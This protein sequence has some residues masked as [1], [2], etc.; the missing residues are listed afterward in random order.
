MKRL[1]V[2]GTNWLG[3][4]V[5]TTPAL[6]RLREKFPDAHIALLTPEKLEQ[7]WLHHPAVD[8]FI[9]FSAGQ[10]VFGVA[11]K[12]RGGKFDAALVLPNSPRS[13]LEVFLAR[14][15]ARI[16]YARPWRNVFLTQTVVPRADAVKM[17][18]RTVQEIKGL[19][20][21]NPKCGI[22][23]PP[24]SQSAHQAHEYLHL[25]AAL[26]ANEEP[27]QSMLAVT[28][29]EVDAARQKFGLASVSSPI[30]GLNPGAEYGPAKRW[31]IER[32]ITAAKEIQ[33]RNN[34]AWILFGGNNDKDLTNQIQSALGGE[35]SVFNVAGKT[36]LRE[37]MS[38]MK[39]CRLFLTNDT[40]PMHVAAALGVPVVAIFGSTSPELTAPLMAN[41]SS[42][43][44]LAS[45][46]PCSPCF[47]RECPVDFRCMKGTRVETV[48][49]AV[50][51]TSGN[52]GS[53]TG[54]A[55]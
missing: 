19:I 43:Q 3:D 16:G 42:L 40:G 48:V 26:G 32:Y 45:D 27:Q 1:L 33:K 38:L 15:P 44:I 41:E 54:E 31:P 13:A 51:Q 22:R 35:A 49:E 47:L 12:L 14:I 29:E 21:S 18:K 24:F 5:M 39:L 53:V 55:E 30:F 9:S 50:L 17:R 2:R 23:P 52:T 4:A 8:E 7:L 25:V 36:S 46:A 11:A 34:C 28:P 37:L 10:G 6:M 20:E